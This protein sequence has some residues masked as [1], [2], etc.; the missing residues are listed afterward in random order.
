MHFN[1]GEFAL[2]RNLMVDLWLQSHQYDKM[3]PLREVCGGDFVICN[4]GLHESFMEFKK[5]VTY[6]NDL[7][8]VEQM[9]LL[10]Y[11]IKTCKK[12]SIKEVS[13]MD[14]S[15]LFDVTC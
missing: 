8:I 14:K 7:R 13:L 10:T 3:S 4:D 5:S 1:E 2:S 15:I 12:T 11:W 6:Q 9:D